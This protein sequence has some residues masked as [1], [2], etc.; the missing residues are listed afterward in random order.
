MAILWL[1][2]M[3]LFLIALGIPLVQRF[4]YSAGHSGL[5]R[6]IM[7]G[8]IAFMLE[9]LVF[10]GFMG[11]VGYVAFGLG[12]AVTLGLVGLAVSF[13]LVSILGTVS[14]M[15]EWRLSRVD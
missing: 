2:F 9:V 8:F 3:S 5:V 13:I 1:G 4:M 10:S 15:R 11:L 7:E 14:A 6:E 12:G